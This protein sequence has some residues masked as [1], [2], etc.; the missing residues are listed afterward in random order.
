MN[1]GS[2]VTRTLLVLAAGLALTACGGGGGGT[3]APAPEKPVGSAP[4]ES[5]SPMAQSGEPAPTGTAVVTGTVHYE[6]E[7][8]NLPAIKMDA[9][10]GCAKKHDGPVMAEALV[11]GDG[12]TMGNVFVHVKSGLPAGTYPVPSDP[13]VLDQKGCQ[14][15]PHVVG[16]RVGQRFHIRNDDG[17]LHNIHALPEVNKG[18]NQAMPANVTEADHIFDKP[19]GMFKI[20]CDVHPW[21]GAWVSVL[22]NPYFAVTGEDGKFSISGLPAGTYE[23]EAWHEKLGTKTVTVQI[24]DGET[25]TEDFTFSRG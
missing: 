16:V 5:T 1:I 10:P 22:N 4:A 12:N 21:M 20:K 17:L 6:G 3:P 2:N 14:Y 7:V 13:V 11:L 8:P 19:E 9:D 25:K 23:V 24:G 18:F 15:S